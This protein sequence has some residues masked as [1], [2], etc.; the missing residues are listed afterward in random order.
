MANLLHDFIILFDQYKLNIEVGNITLL[1]MPNSVKKFSLYVFEMEAFSALFLEQGSNF[2]KDIV[3]NSTAGP[4]KISVIQD[5]SQ[6]LLKIEDIILSKNDSYLCLTFGKHNPLEISKFFWFIISF[7]K[8]VCVSNEVSPE[9]FYIL[10]KFSNNLG[11]K[12]SYAEAL[13]LFNSWIKGKNIKNVCEFAEME[14]LNECFQFLLC[15][16]HVIKYLITF[17]KL[18]KIKV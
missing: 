17:Y 13:S 14:N 18:C 7:R 9:K 11:N 3:S 6:F 10:N 16:M 1:K 2:L 15:N 12:Y 8:A 5:N 4:I